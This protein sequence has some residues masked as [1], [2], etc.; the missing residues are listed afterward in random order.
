MLWWKKGRV[1][2]SLQRRRRESGMLPQGIEDHAAVGIYSF[3]FPVSALILTSQGYMVIIH[4]FSFFLV[5]LP[6]LHTR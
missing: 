1:L 6:Q 2:G 4:V 5:F 3:Y